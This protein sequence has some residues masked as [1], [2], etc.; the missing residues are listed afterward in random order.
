MTVG[1]SHVLRLER[2]GV[3]LIWCPGC[4]RAHRLNVS[5]VDHPRGMKWFFNGNYS[6][7][8][9]TPGFDEEQGG[10]RC[11]FRLQDGWL[12]FTDECTHPLAGRSA[13]LP[14]FPL[15]HT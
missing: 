11:A 2:V 13:V 5:S 7:P 4:C 12:H 10:Q 6:R 15:F 8:S 14:A 9:F 3:F 1:L